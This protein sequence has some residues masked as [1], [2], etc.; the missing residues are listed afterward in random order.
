MITHG[1]V[2]SFAP[3]EV[4]QKNSVCW[5]TYM[6]VAP[7]NGLRFFE[8]MAA[9]VRMVTFGHEWISLVS[10]SHKSALWQKTL[11][12]CTS[13]IIRPR[14]VNKILK[15]SREKTWIY[16]WEPSMNL[17]DKMPKSLQS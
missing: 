3:N 15:S 5:R 10:L 6:E 8:A 12:F 1:M 17:L 9:L 16:C 14:G 4:E 2:E 11:L 7:V 13:N